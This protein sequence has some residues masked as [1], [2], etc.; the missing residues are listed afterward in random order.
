MHPL[1]VPYSFLSLVLVVGAT[2]RSVRGRSFAWLFAWLAMGLVLAAVIFREVRGD[3]SRYYATFLRLRELPLREVWAADEAN[4]LFTYL[5]WGLGQ[6]GT[7]VYL[8]I[9][10]I[11]VVGVFILT[12]STRRLF[13]SY[14]AALVIFIYSMYPFFIFYIASGLKQALAMA[15]LLAAYVSFFQKRR[16][17]WVWLALAPLF[18]AGAVLAVGMTLLH[19]LTFSEDSAALKPYGLQQ[20]CSQRVCCCPS[21]A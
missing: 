16:T 3:T 15:F 12:W 18:H 11:A 13:D 6:L 1:L 2:D 5:N 14:H 17:A 4:W 10:P 8:L 9:A 19:K 20:Q 7:S 21:R